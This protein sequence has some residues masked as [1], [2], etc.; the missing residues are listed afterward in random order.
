MNKGFLCGQMGCGWI[1]GM[2]DVYKWYVVN[3][4]MGGFALG[5]IWVELRW[6]WV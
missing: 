5:A 1:L 6:G 3:R 4:E 2:E